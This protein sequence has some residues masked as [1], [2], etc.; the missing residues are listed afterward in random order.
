MGEWDDPRP[1]IREVPIVA[2]RFVRDA[3][4]GSRVL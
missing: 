3:T 2:H 4:S 1:D